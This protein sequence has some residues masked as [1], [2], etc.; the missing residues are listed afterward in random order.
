MMSNG[1][2]WLNCIETQYKEIYTQIN[3][4]K[5]KAVNF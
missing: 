4:R 3:D 1:K 5:M 2:I